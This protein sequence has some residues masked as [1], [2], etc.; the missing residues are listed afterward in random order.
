MY[1]HIF[2]YGSLLNEASLRK[3][4]IEAE[5]VGWVTLR[6]Y[7]RK[8]NAVSDEFPDVALNII[9]NEDMSIEGVLVKL[10]VADLEAMKRREVGY[11]MVEVTESIHP[12]DGENIFTFVA[13]DVDEYFGRKMDRSYLQTCLEGIPAEKRDRWL[14]ETIIECEINE[15]LDD[16]QYKPVG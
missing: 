10:P 12:A 16:P 14:A 3:T 15:D 9:P 2:G 4:S 8:M 1:I 5:V 13:P 7:Q 11:E 6:G